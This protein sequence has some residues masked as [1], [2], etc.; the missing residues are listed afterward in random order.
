MVDNVETELYVQYPSWS[1]VTTNDFDVSYV[2]NKRAYLST[3][4]SL[5]TSKYFKPNLLGGAMEYDV[6]LS[7]VGCG[8]ISAIYTVLMPGID[9]SGDP[10]QYCD[11]NQVGGHWCPEFDIMEA[12]KYA[13]HVTGHK[14]DAPTNGIYP[15][16]DRSG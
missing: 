9:N 14:C 16:C 7:K 2:F 11:A 13:F 6:D 5:D 3:V 12:N 8:C 15:S 4:D 1:G 10:F